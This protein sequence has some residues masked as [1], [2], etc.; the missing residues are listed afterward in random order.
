MKPLKIKEEIGKSSKLV[1]EMQKK[2]FAPENNVSMKK[3]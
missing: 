3:S 1:R 2:L